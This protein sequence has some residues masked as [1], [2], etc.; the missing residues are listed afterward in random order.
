MNQQEKETDVIV[1]DAVK[2]TVSSY[3]NTNFNG[4]AN[5]V[6]TEMVLPGAIDL[7]CDAI[8]MFADKTFRRD[9]YYY[10]VR[11][12]NND[13]YS[14]RI[15]SAENYHKTTAEARQQQARG[16]NRIYGINYYP[17]PSKGKA[18]I[19][20][21]ELKRIIKS[22][23]Y[24]TV[25]DFYDSVDDVPISTDWEWGWYNI[26]NAQVVSAGNVYNVRLPKPVA[27][28]KRI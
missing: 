22:D 14:R 8:K 24:A 15:K 1:L 25:A 11:H 27:V 7:I 12:P 23:G 6:L 3:I 17:I 9:S 26:D 4:T 10:D 21:Q 19:A 13:G 18:V 20:I 5:E 2:S 16:I 28:T